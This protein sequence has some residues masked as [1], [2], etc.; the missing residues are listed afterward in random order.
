RASLFT[1]RPAF[2]TDLTHASVRQTRFGAFDLDPQ[3]GQVIIPRNFGEGP[4][5]FSVNLRLS[6][7]VGF[8]EVANARGAAAGG[9]GRG[10]SGGGGG[11]GGRGGRGGGGGAAESL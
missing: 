9:G 2:A 7:T 4:G 6:K 10:G 3:P 1:E 5:F 8:G 11:R